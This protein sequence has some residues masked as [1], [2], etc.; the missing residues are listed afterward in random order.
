MQYQVKLTG[1]TQLHDFT[2]ALMQI[3][4]DFSNYLPAC[5]VQ[6]GKALFNTMRTNC[7]KTYVLLD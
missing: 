2:K 1:K 3:I 4:L 7:L 5:H 6:K